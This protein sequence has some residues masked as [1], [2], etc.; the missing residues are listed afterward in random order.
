M[1]DG[2][3][4][5][6]SKEKTKEASRDRLNDDFGINPPCKSMEK[7]YYTYT[8]GDLSQTIYAERNKFRIVIYPYDQRFKEILQTRYISMACLFL[9]IW[10]FGTLNMSYWTFFVDLDF[11]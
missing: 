1:I 10:L 6:L 5:C 2:I 9:K 8:E 7:I 3:P 4:V 11:Y